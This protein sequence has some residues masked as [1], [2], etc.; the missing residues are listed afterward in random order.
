M[1]EKP[2]SFQISTPFRWTLSLT[3]SIGKVDG[4]RTWITAGRA[5]VTA[6][7]DSGAAAPALHLVHL[8]VTVA[9]FWTWTLDIDKH[10]IQYA[11]GSRFKKLPVRPPTCQWF[12][13]DSA[14]SSHGKC[15]RAMVQ[16]QCQCHAGRCPPGH[17]PHFQL[18]GCSC[19][20]SPGPSLESE[21]KGS[22]FKLG[23]PTMTRTESQAEHDLTLTDW[24][25][26]WV[27]LPGWLRPLRL[28]RPGS[29]SPNI[30]HFELSEFWASE[31]QD[32]LKCFKISG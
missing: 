25:A 23:Y 26:A 7:T 30:W 24:I 32:N 19:C 28:F 11:S 15:V 1:A 21:S 5:T 14:T 16:R 10:E 31:S 20:Q 8:L 2:E 4:L 27:T 12:M 3:F 9:D 6:R 17:W 22:E 29:D 18:S 13:L